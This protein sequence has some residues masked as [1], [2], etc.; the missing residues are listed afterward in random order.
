MAAYGLERTEYLFSVYY[1]SFH[2]DHLL[3]LSIGM[4]SPRVILSIGLCPKT[5]EGNRFPFDALS[6]GDWK[7]QGKSYLEIPTQPKTIGMSGVDKATPNFQGKPC[8][9]FVNTRRLFIR[10]SV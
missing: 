4:A 10:V 5:H 8:H 6:S 7:N 1:G 3:Y 9:V 2:Y